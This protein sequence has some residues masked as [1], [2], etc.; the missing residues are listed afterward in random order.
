MSFSGINPKLSKSSIP[1]TFPLISRRVKP[2]TFSVL[3]CSENLETS[4]CRGLLKRKIWFSD[5][6][7]KSITSL[8]ES[9]FNFVTWNWWK[10]TSD[11]GKK[12]FQVIIN[13]GW[14]TYGW[15]RV[16]RN[17]FL[18]NGD[19]R[20]KTFNVINFWLSSL[21]KNCLALRTQTFHI[22]ALSFRINRV[23]KQATIFRFPE[24]PVITISLF[25]SRTSMC[26]RLLGCAVF[27]KICFWISSIC[28][29]GHD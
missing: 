25:R 20:C 12:K 1:A 24:T 27:Y 17:N 4:K 18:L 15:P 23:E 13:F 3:R 22:S 19:W 10:H 5:F 7:M 11:S 9:F 28:S 21:P 16:W 8:T 26:L 2:D 6:W 29:C 14:S